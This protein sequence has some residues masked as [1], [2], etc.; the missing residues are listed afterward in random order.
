MILAS[1]KKAVG[2]IKRKGGKNVTVGG[3]VVGKT[4]KGMST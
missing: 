2:K 1:T 3:K 4:T